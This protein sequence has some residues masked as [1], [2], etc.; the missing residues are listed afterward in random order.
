MS[1]LRHEI[2]ANANDLK[3]RIQKEIMDKHQELKDTQ[4]IG[5]TSWQ[6]ACAILKDYE[7]G[8]IPRQNKFLDYLKSRLNI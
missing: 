5:Y 2:V 1:E 6:I 3:L 8:T 4:D 7:E